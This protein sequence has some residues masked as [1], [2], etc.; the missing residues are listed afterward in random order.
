MVGK[1][2]PALREINSNFVIYDYILPY[3]HILFSHII[4]VLHVGELRYTE[5]TDVT[6]VHIEEQNTMSS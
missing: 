1:T 5:R 6:S 4:N 2:V 3:A